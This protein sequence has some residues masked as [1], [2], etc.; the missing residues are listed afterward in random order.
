MVFVSTWD[1]AIEDSDSKI[2]EEK[3]MNEA[4]NMG[5]GT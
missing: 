2:D 5:L 3:C 1:I 4:L